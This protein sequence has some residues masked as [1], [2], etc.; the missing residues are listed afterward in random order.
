MRFAAR[1]DSNQTAIVK[2]LR[3]AGCNV[4]SLASLGAGCPDLIIHL[5]G[6]LTMIEIKDGAKSASRRKL[7]PHQ[8]RFHR[9]WPVQV[10]TNEM[11]ALEAVG[12]QQIEVAPN[13]NT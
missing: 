3:K 2:A 4:L 10:V 9:D 6:V 5:A 11:E 7:T 12:L 8:V 1:T 13:E